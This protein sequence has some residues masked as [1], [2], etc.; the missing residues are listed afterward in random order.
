MR[1]SALLLLA[2]SSGC[3]AQTA[4]LQS[5]NGNIKIIISDE[6]ST[7]TYSIDFKNKPVI[8]NSALG[9]EFKQ[10]AAFVEGFKIIDVKNAQHDSQWQQPWGERATII[11][12]HNEIAVTFSKAAPHAG[13]YTVR[14]RAFDDGV[15][16]RY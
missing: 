12:Q 7:P 1:T 9:F 2:F 5:P 4:T 16:F 3:F 15:G 11:D 10:Q 13:T 14:F 8:N 6:Q